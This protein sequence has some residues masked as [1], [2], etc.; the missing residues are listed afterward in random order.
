[1][2]NQGGGHGRFDSLG[3]L[4][5]LVGGGDAGVEQQDVDLIS[6]AGEGL[7]RVGY[8]GEIVEVE[9]QRLKDIGAG[10]GP[11]IC[12]GRFGFG[13]GPGGDGDSAVA[14][15]GELGGG[16]EPGPRPELAPVTRAVRFVP[17]DIVPPVAGLSDGEIEDSGS[18]RT[19]DGALAG[20]RPTGGA[21]WPGRPR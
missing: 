10:P 2:A 5:N 12:M 20:E 15:V 16:L 9:G 4:D 17:F 14:F 18:I 19:P 7:G 11:Q 1:M 3:R 6:S 21:R 13:V 8:R